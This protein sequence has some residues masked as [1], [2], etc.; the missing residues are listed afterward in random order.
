ME[1]L[2]KM[3]RDSLGSSEAELK[4][5]WFKWEG[6]S[7]SPVG[8]CSGIYTYWQFDKILYDPKE[9]SVRKLMVRFQVMDL[10][11][12]I[13]RRIEFFLDPDDFH[14]LREVKQEEIDESTSFVARKLLD[15]AV[16][17]PW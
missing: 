12:D 13:N 8:A 5:K 4:D 6:N 9:T 17:K 16:K 14:K 7:Q 3:F 15:S 1:Y 2:D 11:F 10:L